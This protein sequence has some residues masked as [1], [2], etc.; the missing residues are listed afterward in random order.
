MYEFYRSMNKVT[1]YNFV[2]SFNDISQEVKIG[3]LNMLDQHKFAVK[4][5]EAQ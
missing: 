4:K 3:R 2:L 5:S 1:I